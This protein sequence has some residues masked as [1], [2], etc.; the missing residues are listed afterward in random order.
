MFKFA[1]SKGL[2]RREQ[3]MKW[4]AEKELK[5]KLEAREKDKKQPFKVSRVSHDAAPF[6][7]LKPLPKV[8]T[9]MILSD[10]SNLQTCW[11]AL[12]LQLLR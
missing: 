4:K 6:H 11:L 9:F 5:K 1:E 8:R 2:S 7:A 10:F 3:L 12:I